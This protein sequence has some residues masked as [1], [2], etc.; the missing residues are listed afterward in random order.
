MHPT[1]LRIPF[2]LLA[3]VWL[4][5]PAAAQLAPKPA[6]PAKPVDETAK[7]E[8]ISLSVFEVTTDQD[9]GYQ[10]TNAAEATR[11]NTPIEN[12]PM[13]VTVFNQQFIEDL[14]ATDTS[15]LLAYEPSAV[16]TSEN[17][18]FLARGFRQRGRQLSQWLRPDE[19][20]RLPAV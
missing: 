7:S 19:W 8:T 16:K 6:T 13:N 17:D 10:S 14:I 20:F 12:I 4:A 3:G 1:Y 15:A 2:A 9:I 5:A 11:M 18:G